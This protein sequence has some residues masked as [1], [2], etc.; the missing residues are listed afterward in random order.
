MKML[1]T[2]KI[3]KKYYQESSPLYKT[4]T[5]HSHQVCNKALEIAHRHPELRLDKRFIAEA[6]L[7]HDIGIFLCHAPKIHC[8]GTA[9]YIEHGY[10][11]ADILRKE[12]LPRHA[13]VA[14]RHT[15]T[16]ITLEQ[17]VQN[18]LPLPHRL[19]E[20]ESL[21][22]QVVSYADKFYSKSKLDIEHSI[23]EIRTELLKYGQDRAAKFDEWHTAFG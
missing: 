20:P 18:S 22:E 7:L 4:L 12:G 16:G 14:E 13:L 17:I 21:E 10:L 5:V 9:Q 23:E 19:M 3:I 11:G 8:F 15:G 1:D 6:A 2:T